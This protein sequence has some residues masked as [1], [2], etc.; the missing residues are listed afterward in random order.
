MIVKYTQIWHLSPIK[1]QVLADFVAEFT[2]APNHHSPLKWNL[3]VDGSLNS[4]GSCAGIILE[5]PKGAK[6]KQCLR[7][8]FKATNNQAE[9]E[10]VIAGILLA[11]DLE[12]QDLL[13]HSD[14]QL[15]VSQLNGDYQAKDDQMQKYLSKA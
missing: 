7:F 15:V 11:K 6:I 8:D 14:S 2:P 12:V 4:K 13:I 10:A 5:T 1:A 3:H 9:Y